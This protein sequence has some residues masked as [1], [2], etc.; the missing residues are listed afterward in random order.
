MFVQEL[1]DNISAEGERDATIVFAPARHVF[2]GVGPQQVTQQPLI[3][4]IRGSHHTPDL[5]HRLQ[6]WRQA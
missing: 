1:R 6:V 2:V 4:D 3:R 5:L